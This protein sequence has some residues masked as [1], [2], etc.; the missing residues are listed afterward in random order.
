[1]RPGAV[2]TVLVVAILSQPVVAA[3]PIQRVRDAPHVRVEAF[4]TD[5]GFVLMLDDEVFTF[6]PGIV[7]V[8]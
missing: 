1:M 3:P 4:N 7:G 6:Q 5:A 2:V 8:Q